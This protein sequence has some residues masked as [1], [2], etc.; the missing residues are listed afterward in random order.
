MRAWAPAVST[1]R[2]NYA[3]HCLSRFPEFHARLD[4]LQKPCG[5]EFRVLQRAS[6]RD[7][8]RVSGN[9]RTK[10]RRPPERRQIRGESRVWRDDAAVNPASAIEKFPAAQRER[11]SV[12]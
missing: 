10:L 5:K 4:S 9:L 6:H 3:M 1:P 8:R 11:G 7:L 2:T 12:P